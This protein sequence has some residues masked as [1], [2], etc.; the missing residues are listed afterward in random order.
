MDKGKKKCKNQSIR[1]VNS[2]ATTTGPITLEVTVQEQKLKLQKGEKK[3][4]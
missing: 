1:I 4:I 2:K 3:T